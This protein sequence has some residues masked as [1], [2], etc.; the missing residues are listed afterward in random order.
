MFPSKT[1]NPLNSVCSVSSIQQT[2]MTNRY[3][4][5]IIFV[6]LVIN[7]YLA[8]ENLRQKWTEY[9][10]TEEIIFVKKTVKNPFSEFTQISS[11]IIDEISKTEKQTERTVNV[12]PTQLPNPTTQRSA[13]TEKSI[14]QNKIILTKKYSSCPPYPQTSAYSSITPKYNLNREKFL[15]PTLIWGPNN[16]LEGL[17]ETIALC[18]KLNRTLILPKLYR[19]YIDPLAK[20]SAGYQ[21]SVDPGLRLSINKLRQLISV[22]FITEISKICKNNEI[23]IF[24]ARSMDSEESARFLIRNIYYFDVYQSPGWTITDYRSLSTIE[25]PLTPDNFISKN[26]IMETLLPLYGSWTLKGKVYDVVGS[27]RPNWV[28]ATW[29]SYKK[30]TEKCAV[31]HLPMLTIGLY[32]GKDEDGIDGNL[33]KH[34]T[35]YYTSTPEY[36]DDL[37]DIFR[38][39]KN[40]FKENGENNQKTETFSLSI[41][42]HWRF[43]KQDWLKV[44]ENNNR[45]DK[46]VLHFQSN[47]LNLTSKALPL[48]K[49]I[50]EN[51]EELSRAILDHVSEIVKNVRRI[52]NTEAS[53]YLDVYIATPLTETEFIKNVKLRLLEEVKSYPE[54]SKINCLTSADLEDWKNNSMFEKDCNWI[55]KNWYE[56]SSLIEQKLCQT[57]DVFLH[58]QTVSTWSEV[59]LAR[60]K[61]KQFSNDQIK[62]TDTKLYEI[63]FQ[64]F[65]KYVLQIPYFTQKLAQTAVINMVEYKDCK[66]QFGKSFP[67]TAIHSFMGAGNTWMRYL[68][69]EATGFYTGSCY[70]DADL[71]KG[72]FKGE[73]S[74][75]DNFSKLIGIKSH[76][77]DYLQ[78]EIALFNY[79]QTLPNSKCVIL[80]RNPF[81]AFIAEFNRKTTGSHAGIGVENMT[82]FTEL[83]Q[84][85]ANSNM[86]IHD[87]RWMKTYEKAVYKCR[88]GN[89]S[90]LIV[91]YENLKTDS[92]KEMKKVAEYLNEYSESRFENCFIGEVQEGQFHRKKT[93][94]YNPFDE[95]QVTLIQNQVFK[96]NE[97]LGGILPESYLYN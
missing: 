53:A 79:I 28:D 84:K 7:L 83:F 26:K 1:A 32:G 81:H 68:I 8:V 16:Q 36:V 22:V 29:N 12:T 74:S 93:I 18:I 46:L 42:V 41:A 14:I 94:V 13:K 37:I 86:W 43:D 96:L 17:K 89:F 10:E 40:Y 6:V 23:A 90:P 24:P 72:G 97:T 45:D 9:D 59:V 48:I 39:Q 38:K 61:G 85:D 2:L 56:I 27:E 91:F 77:S 4:I 82:V 15:V 19:H 92:L 51:P 3:F 95:K 47:G 80:V 65:D 33:I 57:P 60:R 63:S 30:S 52:Q 73:L 78:A 44:Q 87:D 71:F 20:D 69:E 21:D 66:K 64:Q 75:I 31:R 55:F 5:T 50:L 62:T 11:E 54:I 35:S 58:T 88:M 25:S 67:P 76:N 34:E 70:K 49:S